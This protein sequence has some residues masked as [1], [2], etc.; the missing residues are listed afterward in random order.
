[1]QVLDDGVALRRHIEDGRAA[2]AV[3][4]GGGYIGLEMAEALVRHGLDVSLV[5]QAA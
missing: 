5:E 4:V 1:V 2:R 3:V